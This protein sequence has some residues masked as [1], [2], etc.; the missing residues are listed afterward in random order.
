GN[1]LMARLLRF[2]QQAVRRR[3]MAPLVLAA[4][5]TAMARGRAIAT[6]FA[7]TPGSAVIDTATDTV[8]GSISPYV[9]G[10]GGVA[11][12]PAGTRVYVTR[13]GALSVIDTASNTVVATVS[14]LPDQGGAVAVNPSGTRVYAGYFNNC[15]GCIPGSGGT[16]TAIIDTATNTE[17]GSIPVWGAG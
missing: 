4:L 13:S 12:N 3:F 9:N 10:S 2:G 7:Y 17:V 11:M 5:V 1:K 6:P 14:P 15:G 8:V 16:R